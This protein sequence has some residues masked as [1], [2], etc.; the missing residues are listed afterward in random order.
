MQLTDLMTQED[1]VEFE[2]AIH[3]ATGMNAAVFD[4]AGV[5]VT[6][7]VAWANGVCPLIKGDAGSAQAI[8]AVAH[9]EIARQAQ[10]TGQ[11][12]VAECDG[13]MLKICVPIIINGTFLGVAGGC[14][15]LSDE[16]QLET[17]HVAR[18]TGRTEAEIAAL[19]GGIPRA[20]NDEIKTA[21][22][23][24]VERLAQALTAAG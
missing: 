10:Q 7:Y 18:A 13:G 1:W 15:M 12:A 11:P 19:A 8:C 16:G 17:F 9:Q 24:I 22:A 3:D 14:G 21:V 2:K 20:A 4:A 6:S 23:F 5:R